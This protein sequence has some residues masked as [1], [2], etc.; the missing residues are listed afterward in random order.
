MKIIAIETATSVCGV[1]LS[2]DNQ[3]VAE[4]RL[5]QKNIHNEKL[6]SAIKILT[7]DAKWHL[8]ELNGIAVSIGPGSFTGLRIG[9]TVCKGLAFTLGIPV[10]GVNTLD[11][12]AYQAHLWSGQICSIIKAR[13]HE[14]YCALYKRELETF[15]R[16]S[17]YQIISI[18][19]LGNYIKEK[20]LVVSNPENLISTTL[21][22]RIV[23]PPSDISILSPF[24]VTRLGYTKLQKK[25][26]EDVE[27][28]EPFYLKE[29]KSKRKVYY[30]V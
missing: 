21:S 22:N 27:A 13:E 19:E 7:T 10:V 17:D 11:A 15:Q 4:Y 26:T 30:G 6:I 16:C 8:E 25:E 12:L 23:L 20:T 2:E 28:L 3:L 9:I 14:V 5:N 24:T 18:E 1:A 29:F